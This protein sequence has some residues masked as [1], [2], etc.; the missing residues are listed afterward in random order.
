[1]TNLIIQIPNRH[2]NNFVTLK[3]N[4]LVSDVT[5]ISLSAHP[6]CTHISVKLCNYNSLKTLKLAEI[7]EENEENLSPCTNGLKDL[8]GVICIKALVTQSIKM[9]PSRVDREAVFFKVTLLY[10]HL[11]FQH[12]IKLIN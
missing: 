11:F 12:L 9:T 8:I 2:T 3:Q 7:R 4:Y 10:K 1:M 6:P 5:C